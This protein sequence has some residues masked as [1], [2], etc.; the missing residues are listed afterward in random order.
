MIQPFVILWL[1]LLKALALALCRSPILT[2]CCTS[3]QHP[4]S[5]LYSY[6]YFCLESFASVHGMAVYLES[7]RTLPGYYFL[8]LSLSYYPKIAIPCPTIIYLHYWPFFLKISQYFYYML[9]YSLF[10]CIHLYCLCPLIEGRFQKSTFLKSLY[11]QDLQQCLTHIMYSIT[12][13]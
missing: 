13:Y 7:L 11:L 10:V 2:C 12:V 9:L 5:G 1:H 4:Q 8:R 3:N 6:W